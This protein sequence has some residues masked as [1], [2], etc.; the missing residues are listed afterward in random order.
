MRPDRFARRIR[1]ESLLRPVEP[2]LR[3][4]RLTLRLADHLAIRNRAFAPA[5]LHRLLRHIIDE[6]LRQL[7]LRQSRADLQNF[8]VANFGDLQHLLLERLDAA[9]IFPRAR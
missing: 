1:H 4:F 3:L 7:R 2:L 5:Q 9:R 6:L 8:R